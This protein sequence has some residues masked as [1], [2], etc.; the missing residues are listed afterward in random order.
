MSNTEMNTQ[1]Q[2][3]DGELSDFI[4][5]TQI[6]KLIDESKISID[7]MQTNDDESVIVFYKVNKKDYNAIC[8]NES[9]DGKIY[10]IYEW[11]TQN[12][13]LIG[14]GVYILDDEDGEMH[15]DIDLNEI[16]FIKRKKKQK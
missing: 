10:Q 6:Q 12:G 3:F 9:V 11:Y 4:P 8:D 2:K 15:D 13:D 5:T 7:D 1:I 14:Y 16:I